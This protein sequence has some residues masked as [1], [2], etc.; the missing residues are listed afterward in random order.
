MG[1]KS[2]SEVE[3]REFQNLLICLQPK[4]K[5]DLIK[6]DAGE[7]V[8]ICRSDVNQAERD[9]SGMCT[10]RAQRLKMLTIW[11]GISG[12]YTSCIRC[13]DFCQLAGIPCDHMFLH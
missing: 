4:V 13:L 2:F 3:S 6:H 11:E 7:S 9:A 1:N 5:K 12:K 8:D 10:L